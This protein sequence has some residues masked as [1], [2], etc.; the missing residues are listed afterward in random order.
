MA[1]ERTPHLLL[2]LKAALA[3]AGRPLHI[4]QLTW[5]GVDF[6]R[7]TINLDDPARD[8][9]AKGRARVAMNQEVREALIE[10]RRH[11]TSKYV[12]EFE[13]KPIK[14][15]KGSLERA[16]KRSGIKVS[17]PMCSGTQRPC[18]WARVACRWRRSARSWATHTPPSPTASMP[19]SSRPTSRTPSVIFR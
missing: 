16:A 13:G 17:P 18:G 2:F 19:A 6:H 12:I 3:T 15:V 8:R 11:A 1:A 5:D 10:A 4:L 14:R 9:T 7:R